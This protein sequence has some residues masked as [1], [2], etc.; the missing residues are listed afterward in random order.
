[1]LGYANGLLAVGELIAE[2]SDERRA[3]PAS[4]PPDGASSTSAR[5]S[6]G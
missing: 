5:S 3:R 1:L 6:L 4:C 2:I